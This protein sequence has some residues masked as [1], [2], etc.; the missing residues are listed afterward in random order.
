[1][2]K[3]LTWFFPSQN[4]AVGWAVR[5]SSTLYLSIVS[6][7]VMCC[8]DQSIRSLLSFKMVSCK[9]WSGITHEPVDSL[10]QV[11]QQGVNS[12]VWSAGDW[13][14]VIS[15][16]L[17]RVPPLGN[18]T[19][20]IRQYQ[21]AQSSRAQAGRYVKLPTYQILQ[22]LLSGSVLPLH[23][24]CENSHGNWKLS[25]PT[26]WYFTECLNYLLN[27]GTIWYIFSDDSS[28]LKNIYQDP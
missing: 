16:N 20:V 13:E 19:N 27:Q 11:S 10:E 12:S 2:R 5:R 15:P 22:E 25:L 7:G 18:N 9:V 4:K 3:W 1:M 14:P 26:G 6:F 28:I 8:C 24:D 21:T 17:V 23:A